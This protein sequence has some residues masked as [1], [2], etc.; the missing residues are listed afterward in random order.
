MKVIFEPVDNQQLL[1]QLEQIARKYNTQVKKHDIGEGHIIFVK[2][3]IKITEKIRNN[4]YSIHVWGATEEDITYLKQFWGDPAQ[5]LREGLTPAQFADELADIPLVENLSK[6]ELMQT[7]GITDREYDQLERFIQRMVRRP[8]VSP[9]M[10]KASE[11]L[12]KIN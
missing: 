9:E 12:D 8:N 6:T 1:S 3:R 5:E 4:I 2:S 11:I 7:L 10:K